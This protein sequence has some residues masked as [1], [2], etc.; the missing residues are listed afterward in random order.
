[1]KLRSYLSS[2][3]T[4]M[5]YSD[6]DARVHVDVLGPLY[7]LPGP[8]VDGIHFYLVWDVQAGGMP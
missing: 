7:I 1:M 2:I 3:R 4:I 6:V 5:G 8:V